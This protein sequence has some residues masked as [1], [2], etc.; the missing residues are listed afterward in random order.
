MSSD[1]EI[2]L[3]YGDL[4]DFYGP[5]PLFLL[6]LL[7]DQMKRKVE[8]IDTEGDELECIGAV[9]EAAILEKIGI[10]DERNSEDEP[11]H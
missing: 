1:G 9:F 7:S 11:T 10:I 8:F 2:V 6:L 4:R 3:R 5:E